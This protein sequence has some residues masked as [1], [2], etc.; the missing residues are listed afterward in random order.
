[1]IWFDFD[2]ETQV[3][4]LYIYN[5]DLEVPLMAPVIAKV[6]LNFTKVSFYDGIDVNLLV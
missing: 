5:F 4:I 1:M 6:A 2:S 3:L